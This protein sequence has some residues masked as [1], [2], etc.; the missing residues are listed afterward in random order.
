MGASGWHYYVRYEPDIERAFTRLRHDVFRRGKYYRPRPLTAQQRKRQIVE[1][2]KSL[3]S[4]AGPEYDDDDRETLVPIFTEQ[5]AEL[6]APPRKPKRPRRIE[7][8][9]LQAKIASG[10]SGTHSILDMKRISR[11]R[12]RS[13]ITPVS[14]HRLVELFGTRKPQRSQVETYFSELMSDCE[15]EQGY[16]VVIY[17]ATGNPVQILFAG[18]SGD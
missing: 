10:E 18:S 4:C 9:I 16:Y 8:Q 2:E 7:D 15:R 14:G 6:R 17:S 5:L 13:R 12:G 1:L 11:V 3:A